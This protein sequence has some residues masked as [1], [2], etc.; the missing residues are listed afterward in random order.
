[1]E[2]QALHTVETTFKISY[3]KDQYVQAREYV[4]DM[5]R[6]KNRIYWIGKEGKS[7]EE[8]ILSLIAHR[9]LSGFYNAYEGFGSQY[10]LA[11]QN[12]SSN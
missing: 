11:M 7:D 8:L 3:T 10:I 12:I 2:N 6:H 9:I 1:M 4:E 5:K